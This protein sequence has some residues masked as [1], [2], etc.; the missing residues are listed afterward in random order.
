MLAKAAGQAMKMLNV[1][2]ASRASS[3]PQM[4]A[5]CLKEC[6]QN[7]GAGLLA[8]A[9]GQAMKMLDVT[10]P[11]RASSLPQMT[12]VCLKEM[13]SKCGSGLARESGGPGNED[14]ECEAVF[15]SRLAPT[16]LCGDLE[17][18]ENPALR[19]SL[20]T[21]RHTHQRHVLSLHENYFHVV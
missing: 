4:T 14:V 6:D 17:S 5:V 9:A 7:V 11:S 16:G 18:H 15:A 8:K 10:P 12:A 13:R 19:F 20:I 3:L 1:K 21:T 2:P